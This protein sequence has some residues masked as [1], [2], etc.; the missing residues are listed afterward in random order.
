MNDIK[1]AEQEV[2]WVREAR[3]SINDFVD[4]LF[5][6]HLDFLGTHEI[7]TAK[8]EMTNGISIPLSAQVETPIPP[9]DDAMKAEDIIPS[10]KKD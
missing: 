9:V 3:K 6:K 7:R 8:V 1:F 4:L 2:I 5:Q 10:L